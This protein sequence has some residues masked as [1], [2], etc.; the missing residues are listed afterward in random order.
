MNA[1]SLGLVGLVLG[2]CASSAKPKVPTRALANEPAAVVTPARRRTQAWLPVAPNGEDGTIEGVPL[3]EVDGT[4]LLIDGLRIGDVAAVVRDGR[5]TRLTPLFEAL[6]SRRAAWLSTHAGETWPGVVA[7]R[8]G[9][10]TPAS[11]VKSVVLTSGYAGCPSGSLLVETRLPAEGRRRVGRLAIDPLMAPEPSENVL[12]VELKASAVVVTWKDSK[13]ER[14]RVKVLPRTS[15][16]ELSM[17]ELASLNSEVGALWED[18]GL[19]HA[20]TDPRVD[21]AILHVD[22]ATPYKVL[23][24]VIDSLYGPRR[25]LVVGRRDERVPALNVNLAGD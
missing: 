20:P 12:A 11:V 8:F 6:R 21:Q 22:N 16:S 7:Y 19:H 10:D 4:D 23:I 3:V 17:A 9:A 13:S 15:P 25:S 14:E 24:G 1:I 18:A 5:T 2:G